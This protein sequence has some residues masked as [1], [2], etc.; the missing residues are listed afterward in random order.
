MFDNLFHITHVSLL[1][2][3]ENNHVSFKKKVTSTN[4]TFLSHLCLGHINLNKIQRLAKF[5]A[6]HSLV[7]ED[8]LICESCIEGKITKRPFTSKEVRVKECLKLVHIDVCEP[9]NV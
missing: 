1:S 5:G 9:F 7:P 4:K 6:L 2:I 8:L 3:V